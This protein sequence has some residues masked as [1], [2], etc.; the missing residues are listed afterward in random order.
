MGFEDVK[1]LAGGERDIRQESVWSLVMRSH[2]I[3]QT[4][5][6]EAPPLLYHQPE[7]YHLN[8]SVSLM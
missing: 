1:E 5:N 7:R 6:N 8:Y 2:Y 3:P 4:N